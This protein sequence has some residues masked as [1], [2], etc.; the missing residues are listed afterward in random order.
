MGAF[1]IYTGFI[2][3]DIFSKSLHLWTSGWTFPATNRTAVGILS[4]NRYPFG[5]DPGWHGSDNALVFTN[6][7]KMKMSIVLGV[8]HVSQLFKSP[9]MSTDIICG[10]LDDVCL[11]FTSAQP[12]QVQALLRYLHQLHTANHFFAVH[13]WIP[14][15]LYPVQMVYW[16][17]QSLDSAAIAPEHVNFNVLIAWQGAWEVPI[18]QRPRHRSADIIASCSNLRAL[19]VTRQALSHVEGNA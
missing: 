12:P 18:V 7:F 8:I 2:Y 6:S 4:E 3:N 11:V 17:V 9:F 10:M 15:S 16:L 5:L 13:F 14:C 19:V 1:S